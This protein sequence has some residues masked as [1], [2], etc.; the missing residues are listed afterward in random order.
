MILT[1][2]LTADTVISQF[3]GPTWIETVS[4]DPDG[5]HVEEVTIKGL[6]ELIKTQHGGVLIRDAGYIVFRNTFDG[7]EFIGGEIVVNKGP[8]PEAESDFELFCQSSRRRSGSERPTRVINRVSPGSR[9]GRPNPR[10]LLSASGRFRAARSRRPPPMRHG[11]PPARD[12]LP[13]RTRIRR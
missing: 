9:S 2:P 6:P 8:H 3:A 12:R 10:L 1:N 13:R 7:D 11:C 5:L 4:G